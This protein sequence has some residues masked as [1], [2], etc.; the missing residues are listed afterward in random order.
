MGRESAS[1]ASAS[2]GSGF[3]LACDAHVQATFPIDVFKTR[4]QA[5]TGSSKP[6]SLY[7]VGTEAVRKEGWRVMFAGLGPTLI[8]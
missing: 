6:L 4:M 8:R 2:A 1:C 3:E 5:V 7:K